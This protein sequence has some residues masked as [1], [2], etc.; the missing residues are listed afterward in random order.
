MAKKDDKNVLDLSKVKVIKS[1]LGIA[2]DLNG[3]LQSD[4]N[5]TLYLDNNSFAS[6]CVNK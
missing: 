6:L 5:K 4:Y 3:Q 1:S 2:V